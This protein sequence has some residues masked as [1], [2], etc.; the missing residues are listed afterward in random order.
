MMVHT[1]FIVV[2]KFFRRNNGNGNKITA[3]RGNEGHNRA[4]CL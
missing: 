4:V 3:K 1:S 2:A